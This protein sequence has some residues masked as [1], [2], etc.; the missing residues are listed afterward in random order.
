MMAVINAMLVVAPVLFFGLFAGRT[1]AWHKRRVEPA[2]RWTMGQL[3]VA[4]VAL[5]LSVAIVNVVSIA[6]WLALTA[7]TWAQAI[8]AY[9]RRGMPG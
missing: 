1:W 9:K 7:V 4:V 6:L 3:A 5:A 2:I 8:V